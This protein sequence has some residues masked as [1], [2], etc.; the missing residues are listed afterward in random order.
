[1][2]DLCFFA[3]DGNGVE[4]HVSGL[5]TRQLE[6][7]HV[8]V[9]AGT[10]DVAHVDER[11]EIQARCIQLRSFCRFDLRR[12]QRD[13]VGRGDFSFDDD[14]AFG[15]ERDVARF[16]A[17][18]LRQ[19][20]R[21]V[22]A[23]DRFVRRVVGDDRRELTGVD[24]AFLADDHALGRDEDQMSADFLGFGFERVDSTLNVDFGIDKVVQ[25]ARAVRQHHIGDVALRK[26]KL[27]EAIE[28]TL[29]VG[30]LFA[31][32]HGIFAAVLIDRGF[33]AIIFMH[34]QFRRRRRKR[35]QDRTCRQCRCDDAIGKFQSALLNSSLFLLCHCATSGC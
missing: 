26:L 9:D 18:E 20:P 33:A 7:V 22:V 28:G 12:F 27:R 16:H 14:R 34:G 32:R 13:A 15:I 5:S 10:G 2:Y 3:A 25:L 35:R 4:T 23:G 17:F 19:R 31:R 8:H 11:A 24:G 29:S 6:R 1:M 21:T 30:A